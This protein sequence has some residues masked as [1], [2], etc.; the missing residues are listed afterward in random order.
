[1]YKSP[2]GF[3]TLFTTMSTECDFLDSIVEGRIQAL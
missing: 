3:I 1:M 2:F